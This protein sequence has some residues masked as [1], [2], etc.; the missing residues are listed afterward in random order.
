MR[1]VGGAHDQDGG[2]EG[3]Q[4][5]PELGGAARGLDG[6]EGGRE[7]GEEEGRIHSG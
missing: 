4:A 7:G 1:S 5:A 6:R 3:V 2:R